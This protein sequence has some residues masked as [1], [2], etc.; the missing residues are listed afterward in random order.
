V[1]LTGG[2]TLMI[3]SAEIGFTLGI[4]DDG[5]RSVIILLAIILAALTPTLFKYLHKRF[6]LEAV[7]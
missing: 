4:I 6:G 5:L 2:L 1:L 7:I 3:A